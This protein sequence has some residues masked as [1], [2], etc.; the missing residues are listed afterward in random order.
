MLPIIIVTFLAVF[1]LLL[2]IYFGVT[3]VTRSPK[4]ELKRR[5]QRLARDTGA[6]GMPEDLRTEIIREIPPLDRILA[7]VPLTRDLD[8]KLD[9]AGLDVT[10]SRFVML[11]AAV[12][13]IGF[14]CI[15]LLSKSFLVALAG[16]VMISLLPFAFLS[17][18]IR[19]RLE[20][21]TELFPDALTM[22]SRSLRAGHS[23]TSAIQLV[24][25]EIQDPVGE[26]FKTAYEQQ[27][28]GLRITETLTNLN[29]RIESLDLRFFTTAIAINNDV[30]GNL[31]EILE[32]LAK[33]IRERLKIRRQVRVYTAQGRMTGYV[34]GVLPAFTFVVFNILNHRYESLLYKETQGQYV[35]ALAVFL[36][37]IGFLVIR[38]IIRIRI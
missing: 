30:G 17:F 5:L 16:A 31:S 19:Q 28:L 22:I 6:Q 20:K 24:G 7:K 2:A 12:T 33:T 36:Q 23:F 1:F 29:E 18:K 25:E 8:K 34:L 26:L 32:N 13:V 38:K 9:Y 14:I 15:V 4:Y 37:I 27:L 21:F 35:L 10:A 3:S 11:S